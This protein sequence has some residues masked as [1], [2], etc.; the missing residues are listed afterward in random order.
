MKHTVVAATA[1]LILSALP[2]FA[3]PPVAVLE[4]GR[5]V[6]P[7]ML[8]LPSSIDGTVSLG[9]PACKQTSLT[10]SRTAQFFIGKQEV[11]FADLKRHLKANPK[12]SV[13]V[14][15]PINQKVI[16][17]ISASVADVK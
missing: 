9:C 13:L 5:E 7:A 14:V 11:S 10:L 6:T 17:R 16:T 12:S 3:R 15:S 8:M 1:V 2:A 4:D